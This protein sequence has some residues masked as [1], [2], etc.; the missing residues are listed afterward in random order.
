MAD[1]HKGAPAGWYSDPW[2]QAVLRYWDGSQW[3]HN[4]SGVR[5]L[6]TK[7]ERPSAFVWA[8]AIIGAVMLAGMFLVWVDTEYSIF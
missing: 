5:P 2:E 4:A 7:A 8:L 3:T 6:P 1:W